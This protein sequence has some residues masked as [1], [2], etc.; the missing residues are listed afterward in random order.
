M[1]VCVCESVCVCVFVHVYVCVCVCACVCV[2]VCVRITFFVCVR[3]FF[4]F[5]WTWNLQRFALW[6]AW[7]R[8]ITTLS[9]NTWLSSDKT[10]TVIRINDSRCIQFLLVGCFSDSHL[11]LEVLAARISMATSMLSSN[12]TW[13]KRNASSLFPMVREKVWEWKIV[14]ECQIKYN[15]QNVLLIKRKL[16]VMVTEK[17]RK[18]VLSIWYSSDSVNVIHWGG[19]TMPLSRHSVGT[20]PETSSHATCQGTFSHSHLRC[21]DWSRPKEWH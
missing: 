19:L 3:N 1:C 6:N 8:Q 10:E 18:R 14:T 15:I 7:Q 9:W 17:K 21:V 13:R 4:F 16:S 12:Q 20:Y 2:C 5:C 11:P